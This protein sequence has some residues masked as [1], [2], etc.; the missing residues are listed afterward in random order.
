V[1]FRYLEGLPRRDVG[2]G[3]AVD[4]VAAVRQLEDLRMFDTATEVAVASEIEALFGENH[5]V[6]Y[7]AVAWSGIVGCA[8]EGRQMR[9]VADGRVHR[10]QRLSSDTQGALPCELALGSCLVTVRGEASIRCTNRAPMRDGPMRRLRWTDDTQPT[11]RQTALPECGRNMR[12]DVGGS[13][14]RTMDSI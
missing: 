1:S 3:P 8:A 2:L 14:V 5:C 11:S 13:D 4:R 10:M 9:R 12:R 7:F 6:V